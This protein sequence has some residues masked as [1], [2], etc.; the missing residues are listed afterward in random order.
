[1]KKNKKPIII[2]VIIISIV[3]FVA[4]ILLWYLDGED[5]EKQPIES[6]E[7][8]MT[9]EGIFP[10]QIPNTSLVIQKV[11]SYDGVFIEDGSDRKVSGISAIVVENVGDEYIEYAK[12]SMQCNEKQ[13]VYELKLLE[14]KGV[15][16]VQ[17]STAATYE[18]GEYGGCSAEIATMDSM[19]MSTSY[20]SID[21][22]DTG[23]IRITNISGKDI[24]S[25]RIFYKFYKSETKVLLGGITYTTKISNLKKGETR[26]IVPSHYEKGA[27]R[28]MMVRTYDTY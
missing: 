3:L 8:P 26:E 7:V 4:G 20:I 10:Y 1:M 14:P 16:I 15:I 9:Q 13:L 5:K 6:H 2:G 17:E 22:T 27:S 23:A 11:R 19:E 21:E 28:I 12:I 25:V 18:D 24:A